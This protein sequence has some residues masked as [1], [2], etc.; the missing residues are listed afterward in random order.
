M[1]RTLSLKFRGPGTALRDS[2]QNSGL[3][4]RFNPFAVLSNQ[5]LQSIHCFR[6]WNVE[7]NRSLSNIEVDLARRATDVTKIGVRHFA[8][9]VHDAAHDRDLYAF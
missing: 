5:I 6:F 2:L 8:G 1:W 9:P 7:L 4:R 3:R